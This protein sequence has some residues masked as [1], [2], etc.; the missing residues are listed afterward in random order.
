VYTA[1]SFTNGFVEELATQGRVVLM[2]TEEN[3][4]SYGAV[5]SEYLISGLGGWADFFGNGDGI[6]SAEEAFAFAQ[7]LVVIA[8]GGEQQPTIS[9]RYSGEFPVT[10]W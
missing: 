8:S 9:D 5:F 2:S 1:E 4:L 10:T 6:N 7:P 3:T